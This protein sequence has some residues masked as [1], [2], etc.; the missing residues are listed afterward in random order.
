VTKKNKKIKI[1]KKTLNFLFALILN[2]S[3][4]GNKITKNK[5]KIEEIKNFK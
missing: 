1:K 5:P 3:I 4:I 2:I